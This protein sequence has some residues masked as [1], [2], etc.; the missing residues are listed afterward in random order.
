MNAPLASSAASPPVLMSIDV[1]GGR[2]T[3]HG[4]LDRSHVDRLDE[5]V[6]ALA[7]STAASWSV[8]ASSVTFCDTEG[9]RALLRAKRRAEAA[10][11]RFVV[12]RPTRCLRRLLDVVGIEVTDALV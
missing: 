11:H 8:D 9:L 2:I 5:A 3:M 7:G 10:G 1:A 12:V 4:E 6:H